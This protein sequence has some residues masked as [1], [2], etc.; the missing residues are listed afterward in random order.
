MQIEI[1]DT[2]EELQEAAAGLVA[3]Y[4]TNGGTDIALAGGN[5]P[6]PVHRRLANGGFD[7]DGVTVWLGDERWVAPDHDDSNTRMARETLV[8]GVG[9]NL[10]APDTTGSDPA[11]SAAHYEIHLRGALRVDDQSRLNPGLVM[12]GMG[13]DGHTASLFPETA[14]LDE[15]DR[16]YVANWVESKQTWRLTATYPTLWAADR[17]IFMVTGANKATVVREIIEDGVEYP[18]Q[19][20]AAGAG[21]VVWLFDAAA[22][23][24]ISRR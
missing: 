24:L 16:D 18:A 12:L 15:L 5:T 11:I 6:K 2:I 14:A 23:E 7:W 4:L 8:D 1:H 20:V 9:A 22:A 3:E 13:D 10:L 21:D 17:V 19:R